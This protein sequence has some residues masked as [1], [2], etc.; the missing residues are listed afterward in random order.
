[1]FLTGTGSEKTQET[2]FK[3]FFPQI[4]LICVILLCFSS[5]YKVH[6]VLSRWF[7][8]RFKV[9]FSMPLLFSYFKQNLYLIWIDTVL[10][11]SRQVKFYKK[12]GSPSFFSPLN[13]NV[14]FFLHCG[15]SVFSRFSLYCDWLIF[16]S[17]FIEWKSIVPGHVEV[18]LYFV[19]VNK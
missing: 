14:F 10:R 18:N 5:S 16:W 11:N 2:Q 6:D 13:I 3:Y 8:E 1:M 17:I 7:F 15:E 4:F 12:L 19:F 9:I